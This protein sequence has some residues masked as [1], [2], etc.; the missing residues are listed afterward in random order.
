MTMTIPTPPVGARVRHTTTYPDG[1]AVTVEGVV[2]P[3]ANHNQV[4]EPHLLIG[5]ELLMAPLKDR[6][7]AYTV[8]LEVLEWPL[9]EPPNGT[10]FSNGVDAWIR[11]RDSY[12]SVH[13]WGV[14]AQDYECWEKVAPIVTAPGW[15]RYIPDPVDG[16]FE[17]PWRGDG[18]T[19][20]IKFH[21]SDDD[22]PIWVEI[23]PSFRTA[24]EVE[25]KA[26]LLLRAVREARQK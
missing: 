1:T 8:A 9:A 11:D 18:D 6:P 26:A 15:R 13:W 24:L 10:A 22:A 23:K 19:I 16:A 14:L 25:Q 5:T 7:G 3:N 4:A 21:G 12:D 17:L 2:A 20:E